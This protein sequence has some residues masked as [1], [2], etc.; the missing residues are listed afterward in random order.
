MMTSKI[1]RVA[2]AGQPNCGKSTM[3]NAIT[4]STARVGNYPGITVEHMEGSFKNSDY[5]IKFTDLPGTYSLTSYSM[6]E[7]VTRNFILEEDPDIILCMIDT[8]ALERSLY[9]VVQLLE[10]GK[11]II[12]GLNMMDEVKK[13]G[14]KIKTQALSE[15][16][17][18]P[19]VECIARKGVGKGEIVDKIIELYEQVENKAQYLDISYGS[20]LDPAINEMSALI[21]QNTF[22]KQYP[23]KWL[24]IKYMEEDENLLSK[25]VDEGGIHN[26]LTEIVKKTEKHTELTLNTYPEAIVADYRYGF[27][28]SLLKQGIINREQIFKHSLTEKADKFLTHRIL[29]PVIMLLILYVLFAVTFNIGAYPQEWIQNF[30]G[31]LGSLGNHYIQNDMLKSL[32]VSGIIDGLGAV[33][34][35]APLI[36]IMFSMLCFLEDL[37]YMARIAYMLD[38]VFKAF[39]LHGS[40]VMP[41]I[42]AGGIPGGCAVPGVMTART[43]R[44]P[45]ERIATILTAP[46]MVCGA[47]TTVF[48]MLCKTFFP[49]NA[50]IIMLAITIASWIFA[51]I[52]AKILR[53]TIIKGAP[54]PFIMELPPYRLPTFYGIL[55]HTFDRIW[56]FIKKAGTIIFAISIVMWALI[57][58]PQLPTNIKQKYDKEKEVLTSEINSNDAVTSAHKKIMILN[59]VDNINNAQ[60]AEALKYSFGGRLGKKLEIITK[61]CGFNWQTNIALVGGFAAKEVILSTLS[62]AYSLLSKVKCNCLI[63]YNFYDE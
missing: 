7:I 59:A 52:T 48:L 56:Q 51:L 12:V 42:I 28:Q 16:L 5:N 44:S 47:K 3:F 33:L 53:M 21:K 63:K 1:I 46:F 27:I 37:G 55:T 24:A 9:L 17:G 10:M 4:G 32:I 43:L 19:I 62:T 34:S 49:R 18:V 25:G 60:K 15:L 39:G 38:R 23:T 54:T 14:T 40:S 8:V 30:F 6:E 13:S 29:G 41:F 57:T 61:Y 45:K 22:L 2:L 26:Q 50:T 35:F 11:P 31:W 36:L 20:D 58:F